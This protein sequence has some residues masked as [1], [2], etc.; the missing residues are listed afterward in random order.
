MQDWPEES[1]Q[2]KRGLKAVRTEHK[3][4]THGIN[5][6]PWSHFD[7]VHMSDVCMCGVVVS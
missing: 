4:T 6:D 7:V 1:M 5:L 3:L 2:C